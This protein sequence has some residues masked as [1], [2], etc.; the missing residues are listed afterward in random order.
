MMAYMYPSDYIV[1]L[2][3][4]R[5]DGK[6]MT[7]NE[8]RKEAN[9]LISYPTVVRALDRLESDNLIRIERRHGSPRG[10]EYHVVK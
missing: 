5:N 6:E 7:Y 4:E 10:N 3:I 9:E 2:V 1:L 8:I